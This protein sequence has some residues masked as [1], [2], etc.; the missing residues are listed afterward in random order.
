MYPK[1]AVTPYGV[2]VAPEGYFERIAQKVQQN[3]GG[4]EDTIN[5][6]ITDDPE[7]QDQADERCLH[8][9]LLSHRDRLVQHDFSSRADVSQMV[10]T[11]HQIFEQLHNR[12]VGFPSPSGDRNCYFRKVF[13]SQ[14]LTMVIEMVI[15][16]NYASVGGAPVA[17]GGYVYMNIYRLNFGK[18]KSLSSCQKFIFLSNAPKF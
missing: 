16:L 9:Y 5:Q 2:K 17:Y 18:V 8:I 1:E 4:E 3:F 13:N 11:V 7:N 6:Q 10:S 14:R 15:N 12:K